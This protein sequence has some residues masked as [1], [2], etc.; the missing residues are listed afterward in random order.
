[1]KHN[2]INYI[3]EIFWLITSIILVMIG[4]YNF[5]KLGFDAAY[6]FF[7]MSFLAV[8]L[9]F[10]RRYLRKKSNNAN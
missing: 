5:F 3:L 7:I 8:L 10:A 9:Y 2:N 1:M 6:M 4:I